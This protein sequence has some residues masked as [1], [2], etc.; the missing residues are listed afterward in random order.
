MTCPARATPDRRG[1]TSRCFRAR[2]CSTTSRSRG[3]WPRR[4]TPRNVAPRVSLVEYEPLPAILTMSDAIAQEAYLA[5]PFGSRAVTSP[6]L[7]RARPMHEANCASAGRSTSILET[8]AAL[9]WLDETGDVVA[10]FVDAASDGDAGDRGASARACRAITSRSSACG[11]AARSAARKRRRIRLRPHRR[12]RRAEDGAAVRVRLTRQ[13]DMAHH[14]QAP[15]VSGALRRRLRTDGRMQALQ[16]STLFR[17][18]LESRSVR[19]RSCGARMFHCDNATSCATVDVIGRVCR[20]HKTSKTAF[21]GFGGPQGMVVIEE[22]LAQAARPS[23]LARRRSSASATSTGAGDRTHYGQVVGDANRM[24]RSGRR[25][26]RPATSTA[27]AR[28]RR[29]QCARAA[30]VKRGL[31]ITPVKFGISFTATFYNQAEC[32]GPRLSRRHRAGEPRRHRDGPGPVHQDSPDRRRR[33]LASPADR[34]RLMPTRT[35]KV[36]NTSATAASSGS[37]LNGAAVADA[38]RQIV[39]AP[40]AG[41]SRDLLGLRPGDGAVRRLAA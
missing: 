18:R 11:W 3:C 7:V 1:V 19:P 4:S 23:G 16:L 5:E 9:A 28:D 13:L 32:A 15:S 38:C 33:R 6:S 8:Q 24:A 21:R 35:D 29:V 37:D 2:S 20:T 39:G 30:T 31:A 12:A 27:V 34:V 14:R 17:R 25:S 26:R 41:G 36:P 10:A 40:D 22:I